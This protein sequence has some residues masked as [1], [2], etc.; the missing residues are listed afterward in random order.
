[1]ALF[2]VEVLVKPILTKYKI[3]N[4][5]AKHHSRAHG[6]ALFERYNTGI[7]NKIIMYNLELGIFM[8]KKS[9]KN[10]LPDGFNNF[11]TSRFIT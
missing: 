10:S 2:S 5:L 3:G 8:Y 6:S 7:L 9:S 11:F 4:K 1:M